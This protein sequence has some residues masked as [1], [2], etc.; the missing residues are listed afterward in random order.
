MPYIQTVGG[1]GNQMFQIA[2]AYAH[3]RRYGTELYIS[4]L[5]NCQRRGTSYWDTFLH[6][7]TKNIG[8][9]PAPPAK[10][11][12]WKERCFRYMPIPK[13]ANTLHGYFQSSK[14]FAD[15]S[16]ELHHLFEPT[17]LV[18]QKVAEKY[19]ALLAEEREKLCVVHVRRGDYTT[20]ANTPIHNVLTP[21]WYGRAIAAVIER[22]P[23]IQL[24][25]FSDDI[26]WCRG[27]PCFQG[28]HVRFIDEPT[29]YLALH[30]MSQFK[31]FIMSNSTFSWWAVW[32]GT[33]ADLVIVPSKWFG[34]AGPQDYQDIYEPNWIKLAV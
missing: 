3:S 1:L 29:D 16:G 14:Y 26:P 21:E 12:L 23:D 10:S 18:K 24:L 34:P 8:A 19:G 31:H 13:P 32:L 30:L 7:F 11:I 28:G 33:P 17:P 22:I 25:V 27:L 5:T 4:E 15:V 9:A 2:A 20:A 6:N